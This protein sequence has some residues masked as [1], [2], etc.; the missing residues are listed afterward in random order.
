LLF[1]GARKILLFLSGELTMNTYAQVHTHR[2]NLLIHLI[3]VPLFIAAHFGLI[4][5]IVQQKP[6]LAL[7]W[8]GLIVVSLGMQRQG[9]SLEPRKPAPFRNGL[10]FVI[11]LY[12]E[13]FYT[14][15]Q[16]VLSGKFRENWLAAAFQD[17]QKRR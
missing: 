12:I 16:F 3:A 17:E 9:H 14:F 8:I 7:M 2:T 5:W 15:P 10:D 1:S 13:Q 6:L 4:F 11:R